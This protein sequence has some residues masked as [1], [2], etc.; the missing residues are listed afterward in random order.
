MLPEYNKLNS[1]VSMF[2]A[3]PLIIMT[4]IELIQL[5]IMFPSKETYPLLIAAFG[6]T[7]ALSGICFTISATSSSSPSIN[8]AGEKFLHSSLLIIQSLTIIFLRNALNEQ[9]F[10]EFN[11]IVKV[12]ISIIFNYLFLIISSVACY[13]FYYGFNE[14]NKYLWIQHKKRIDNIKAIEEVNKSK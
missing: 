3:T 8:Y 13:W 14:L 7:A 5:A 2:I 1:R 6:I 12:I 9:T 11:K 4:A 10:F